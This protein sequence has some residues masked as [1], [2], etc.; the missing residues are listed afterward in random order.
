MCYGQMTGI[1]LMGAPEREEREKQAEK[2]IEE[3]VVRNHPQRNKARN[4]YQNQN[5]KIT[6]KCKKH[7][8]TGNLF[9]QI[10]MK[11]QPTKTHEYCKKHD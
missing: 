7:R 9:R 3:I 4:P 11:T 8:L 5:W 1:P 2:N 6:N 10:K